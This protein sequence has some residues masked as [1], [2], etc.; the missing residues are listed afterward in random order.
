[1]SNN[2]NDI[3]ENIE[4]ELDIS[5]TYTNK[6]LDAWSKNIQTTNDLIKK[7]DNVDLGGIKNVSIQ[8]AKT[9]NFDSAMSD[10]RLQNIDLSSKPSFFEIVKKSIKWRTTITWIPISVFKE[11]VYFTKGFFQKM[12][13]F[14]SFF[15]LFLV[16]DKFLIENRINI[17][18]QKIIS[19]KENSWDINYVEKNINNAR[20]DFIIWDMLFKPFL[21]IPNETIKNWY[22]ILQWWKN[23][24][25][26]LDESIQTYI[27][28]K[29]FIDSKWGIANV[30]LSNL[31]VNLKEDFWY[32]T[33]KLYET[34]LSYDKVW[35][36]GDQEINIKL[37]FAKDKLQSWYKILDI[38]NR[39][40][41]IF[42]NLLAHKWEKKYLILFQNNDEI[43][44]T[45][46]F[47]WS[48]ATVTLKNWKVTDF[49]KDDVYA[50]EWE[51]NKMYTDKKPS[52]EWLN[53][54][55]KTFWLRDANYFADFEASSKSINFFLEKINKDVDWIIYINQ[56]TFLDFLK[57]TWW[58]VFEELWN[59]ITEDNFSLV[60]STLVE[61]QAFKIWT[62]WSPKQILFDFANVFLDKLKNDK[63][64]YAYLDIIIKNI[65][66][67][68]LVIYSFN[69]DENNLLW[70]LWLNWKI[71]YFETLDFAY[72]FYT[73]IWWNKSDR[74]IELKYKKE[75]TQNIDCS[76][77]TNLRIY[78]T[79][80]FSKFEE[81]KVN[82]L[83]DKYPLKD[84]TRKD[85]INIQWRWEN[86][87]YTRVILPKDAI[88]EPNY[89]MTINKYDNSTVLGFYINTRLLE[90]TN[91]NINYK[92][93]NKDC[94]T[95]SYKFYKQPWVRDYF[96]EIKE[97]EKI[98]KDLSVK[99]DFIYK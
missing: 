49:I 86:R 8:K 11:R 38:I 79:H 51:I 76:I 16:I 97:W 56:N 46:G 9:K 63:D 89:W 67:R 55:T 64:Y 65:K 34:I 24:T 71:N 95:Y 10:K 90:T 69:P 4:S 21:L 72:P 43:R 58:I 61:S 93:E 39:D 60:I 14:F 83:L 36:I 44:A 66:S 47:I 62:L 85:V 77:D 73:S 31:L 15:W 6:N 37:D 45:W 32:I 99:W 17:W 96:M 94:N 7:L 40:F 70:K 30:E 3:F 52:P 59:T 84:K 13:L 42:L 54:I 91:Y 82:D 57:L 5:H 33:N 22:F 35:N 81:K 68:D 12:L 98:T 2:I 87:V 80:F 19:I 23:L 1:M 18:Y 41:D 25:K 78:R 74:Y 75:I 27:A 50:Y 28:T 53:K 48:L 88:V 26:L 20:L 29:T 92:L